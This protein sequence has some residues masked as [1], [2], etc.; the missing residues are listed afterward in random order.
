M[1]A[2]RREEVARAGGRRIGRWVAGVVVA[3]AVVG[4]AGA[5]IDWLVNADS[6]GATNRPVV[7]PCGLLTSAQVQTLAPGTQKMSMPADADGAT[8]VWD[9]GGYATTMRIRL[10]SYDTTERA[11][12]ALRKLQ[13]QSPMAGQADATGIGDEAYAYDDT[14]NGEFVVT[15]RR[16]RNVVRVEYDGEQERSNA[17]QAARWADASL[18]LIRD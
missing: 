6:S 10:A 13:N 16:Y 1:H 17:L 12:S 2:P 11:T 18:Q 14:T 4:L 7:D 5:G 15:F 3:A 8:C 9:H